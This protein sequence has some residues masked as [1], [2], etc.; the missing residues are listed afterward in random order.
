MDNT[1]S[2]GLGLK[3]ALAAASGICVAFIWGL[4]LCDSG[5][6]IGF[7]LRRCVYLA[8]AIFAASV[9]FPYLERNGLFWYRFLGMIIVGA[10]SYLC[11]FTAGFWI[12]LEWD[13][14]EEFG[15]STG[16]L[17]ATVVVLVGARLII[18]LSSSIRLMCAGAIAA[19]VGGLVFW[20]P[21]QSPWFVWAIWHILMA[22]AVHAAENLPWTSGVAE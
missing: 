18:P 14:T 16:C 12:V 8:G 21:W 9:F 19:I 11:A 20:L 22:V 6:L 17:V 7:P 13:L 4:A 15:Y 10:I 5:S 2:M 1:R 3:I